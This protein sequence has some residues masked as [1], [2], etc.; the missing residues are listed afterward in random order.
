MTQADLLSVLPLLVLVFWAVGLMLVDLWVP[1][2][3]KG[4]IALLAAVG[5]CISLGLTLTQSGVSTTSMNG[6]VVV[7]GFSVS[8]NLIFLVSGL[9]A[10]ALAYDYLKRMNIER[11]E[12]YTLLLFSISGMMLMANAYDLIIVFLA[13]ELLSIPLYILAGFARPRLDSEEAALKYF[14]LGTFSSA[15][16]LYGIALLYGATGNTHL[17]GIAQLLKEGKANTSLFLGG[18]ALMLVGFGFKVAAVPFHRW[19]PDVYQGAPTSVTGFMSVAVKAAGFAALL[20]VFITSFSGLSAQLT[21]ILFVLAALTMIG[22][23]VLAIAQ[24]NIKRLLAY[25]SIANAGYLL[26]AFVPFGNGLVLSDSV[27]SALFF[28][29]GYGLTSIGAWAVVIALEQAE[30]KGLEINDFSGLAS[31]SPWLALAMLIFMLSFTG[32]PLT[33]GFWGKFYLFRTAVEGGFTSLALIGLITSI[34]SAYYYLRVVV[35]MYMRPGEPKPAEDGWV[36]FTAILTALAV[37]V[38]GFV[39][40]PLLNVA[41]QALLKLP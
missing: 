33:L 15:F 2:D 17:V 5:L 19:S 27:S 1:K 4:L 6:M 9:A 37:L 21:P 36:R 35:V 16:V 29:V 20:R 13:L 32:V 23:N 24:T 34:I 8:L 10:I 22:G 38:F 41:V 14:L 12:Y 30:G 40:A 26:M 18:A 3:R 31:R 11:G 39:P 25:S 7:D 28:L